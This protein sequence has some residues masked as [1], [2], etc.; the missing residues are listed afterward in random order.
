MQAKKYLMAPPSSTGADIPTFDATRSAD[1]LCLAFTFP[2]CGCR[3]SHGA[4]GAKM[5][6]GDGH[7]VSHCECWSA[8]YRLREV[9]ATEPPD[10]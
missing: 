10:D 6:D 1:G 3:N 5:G 8:G 4:V 9:K 7:R 2:S